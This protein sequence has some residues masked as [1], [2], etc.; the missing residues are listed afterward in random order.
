[1]DR[2]ARLPGHRRDSSGCVRHSAR[3]GAC[4]PPSDAL[5]R[6]RHSGYV[7]LQWK[8]GNWTVGAT[9]ILVGRRVDSDFSGLGLTRNPGYGILNLRLSQRLNDSISWFVLVNNA[10]DKEYMEV[11]GYPALRAHFRVGLRAGF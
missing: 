11:L 3:S 6:P 9:T 7:D 1:M 8:P 5:R 2:A 10:L 4:A